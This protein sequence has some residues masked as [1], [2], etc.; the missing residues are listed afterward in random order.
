LLLLGIVL[1]MVF[2]FLTGT[3]TGVDPEALVTLFFVSTS[4]LAGLLIT[5]KVKGNLIG[6]LLL[7]A[8]LCFSLGG[9]AV[10]AVEEGALEPHGWL[11]PAVII[12]GNVLFGLGVSILGTFVLLLFPTGRIPSPRWRIV[13]WMA[14]VG[15]AMLLLGI[16]LDPATFDDLPVPN[17]IA[18]DSEPVLLFLGNAGITLLL[19]AM[20]SSVASLVVR[21]RRSSGAERQQLKWVVF[22]VILMALVNGAVFLWEILNGAGEVTDEVEN[23]AVSFTLGLIPVAFGVAI[24]RYR[25]YDIDRLISRT[26]SYGLISAA[27]VAVYL[28]LV[29]VLTTLVRLEGDLAVAASTLAAA[30]LFN[31]LRSGVQRVIDRR[32][33]RS[34]YRSE[35]VVEAFTE[36]LPSQV[37]LSELIGSVSTVVGQTLQPATLGLW[38]RG[39]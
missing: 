11:Y 20:L 22:A 26:L 2:A 1:G 15:T 7:L 37:H 36:R 21:F 8:A 35:R 30:A 3:G 23:F 4:A 9:A 32:F 14:G 31:P 27:L 16:A 17:P 25:L 24:L 12:A 28:G 34:R 5:R 19:A 13:A 10:T 18:L 38:L 33:H 29:F 6:W 39:Q